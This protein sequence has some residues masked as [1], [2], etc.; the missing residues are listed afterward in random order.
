MQALIALFFAISI[1]ELT[2]WFPALWSYRKYLAVFVLILLSL[3]S[4]GFVILQPSLATIL[5]F[6]FSFYRGVNLFRLITN[7][8][9]ID[10]LYKA[11]YSS[12]LSLIGL[13]SIVIILV[14]I[15]AK[16]LL[17]ETAWLYAI[18]VAQVI[19]GII[20]FTSTNRH[21][22]T[23][24]PLKVTKSFSDRELPTVTVAI[25]ARNETT[26]LSDCLNS[27]ISSN[28]P[29]LEILVLDDCSQ[30]RRTP[31]IIKDFALRGVRFIA[32]K[33]PPDKWLAKNFAYK[34]LVDESSGELIIFC[35]VDTRFEPNT[36]KTLVELSLI[37]NK[38]MISLIPTNNKNKVDGLWQLLVQPSRYAWELALPRRFLNR[39][40]VLSTCWMIS[41]NLL[42]SSGGFEAVTN[43]ISPESYFARRAIADRDGYSFMQADSVVAL[44]SVKSISDQRD[45]AVRTRYPQLHKRPEIIGIVT[46]AEFGALI[47]P[48]IFVVIG[49]TVS[50]PFVVFFAL[51]SA[52]LQQYSYGK[53]VELTYR[54]HILS[55]YFALPLAAIFDIY[56]LNTSMIRYEFGEVIWKDRN[57]CIP[58]MDV[59]D[60]TTKPRSY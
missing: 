40:A 36:I 43:T 58:I 10:H 30:D 25:P 51:I 31:E 32:G 22:K 3:L 17:S 7:R 15:N 59:R 48:M 45:T 34:Q 53:V 37:K 11:S 55:G 5:I 8:I 2:I 1:L 13:Q 26:N 20:V 56:L 19:T 16:Y 47:L 28:Y 6:V 38:Q 24:I 27:L 60:G 12:A 49:V 9:H 42:L 54:K 23:T 33:V 14:L 29:K 41:R 50:N 35:G 57:V 18:V 52:L 39:P 46:A 21:L 44:S 4:F